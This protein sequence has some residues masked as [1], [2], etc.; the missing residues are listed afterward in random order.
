[1]MVRR[2]FFDSLRGFDENFPM[3][4]LEDVDFRER[5]LGMGRA[6]TFVPEAVVD[7]PPRP[8]HFGKHLGAMQESE[9]LFYYKSGHDKPYLAQHLR[10]MIS[11]RAALIRQYPL[12]QESL[13]ALGSLL[14]ELLYV[15]QKGPQW[16]AKYRERYRDTYV[17]YPPDLQNRL[18]QR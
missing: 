15:M 4:H 7:H 6:L 1:M 11:L 17:A 18:C 10:R 14:P 2:T 12:N 3:P 5:A 13:V 8:A 16:Q 9:F